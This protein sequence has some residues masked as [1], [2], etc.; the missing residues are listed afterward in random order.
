[1]IDNT[2]AIHHMIK[3]R[4]LKVQWNQNLFQ[5]YL[6]LRTAEDKK[7]LALLSAQR[8]CNTEPCKEERSRIVMMLCCFVIAI[9]MLLACNVMLCYWRAA[10]GGTRWSGFLSAD[11]LSYKQYKK[12]IML[13]GI[14]FVFQF[15]LLRF[16]FFFH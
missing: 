13:Y 15:L 9:T 16:F 1:M 10:E 7:K 4:W 6:K 14:I 12:D 3:K 2:Q 11:N 8:I 5:F